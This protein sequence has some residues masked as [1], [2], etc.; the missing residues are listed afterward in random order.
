MTVW[1]KCLNGSY[2][3]KVLLDPKVGGEVVKKIFSEEVAFKLG[4][5]IRNYVI[6]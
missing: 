4:F 2:G 6:T 1:D 3:N 5:K